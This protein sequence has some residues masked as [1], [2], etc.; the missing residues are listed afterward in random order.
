MDVQLHY[1][2]RGNGEPFILLHGNGE[3]STYFSHQIAYFQKI[4]RVIAI[5]TRGH[6][7]SPRGDEPFTISQFADDLYYFMR[8]HDIRRAD[9]LGFSDGANIALLFTIRHP[10]RVNRL[11]L[12]SANLNPRGLKTSVQFSLR[13]SYREAKK[14]AEDDEAAYREAELLKLMIK[15]PDIKAHDLKE[16]RVPTLVIA[17]ESD[18]IK[19]SHSR[20]I[21]KKLPA[22]KLVTIPGNH[23]IANENFDLF[24]LE[25][26]RFL[27][28]NRKS[29]E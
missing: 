7:K 3:D 29:K 2:V 20:K 11:I 21:Y 24:N 6:G 17:G 13:K 12:N 26:A 1:V 15:E 5:D 8:E 4:Y 28:E 23:F 25:V 9:M 18:M 16:V 22:A 14:L 19:K 27:E 10:E